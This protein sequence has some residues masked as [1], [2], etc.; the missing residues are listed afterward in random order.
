M[1]FVYREVEG[2]SVDFTAGRFQEDW[3]R[4][5]PRTS[6]E[7]INCANLVRQPA[8]E[9]VLLAPGDARDCRKVKDSILPINSLPDYLIVS[10]V[11]SDLITV[12]KPGVCIEFQVEERDRV[13][14]G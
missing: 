14:S 5:G 4:F 12:Q 11:S 3:F 7:N 8:V 10:D 13:S 6:F 2:F 9:G 1:A